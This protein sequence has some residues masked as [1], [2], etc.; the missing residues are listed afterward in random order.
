MCRQPSRSNN[1]LGGFWRR[2]DRESTDHV[3]LTTL[4]DI[5]LSS[6]TLMTKISMACERLEGIDEQRQTCLLNLDRYIGI[7]TR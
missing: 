1:Q 7:T 3:I 4:T 5:F 2:Q 6:F